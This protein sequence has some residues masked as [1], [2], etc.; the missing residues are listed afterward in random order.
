[1]GGGPSS[2]SGFCFHLSPWRVLQLAVAWLTACPLQTV[3]HRFALKPNCSVV[4][5]VVILASKVAQSL[6]PAALLL[7]ILSACYSPTYEELPEWLRWLA[8]LSPCAY[9]YEGVIVTET[10]WRDVGNIN[11]QSFAQIV[12]GIPR[13]PFD[14]APSALS[15]P[16]GIIAFDAYMLV[17]LTTVFELVGCILLHK[18]QSWYGPSR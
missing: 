15:T 14:T 18:S 3:S 17:F 10:A 6:G 4:A 16:G 13:V 9:T 1:M 8:W 12:F 5:H 11:G 2:T 7:F